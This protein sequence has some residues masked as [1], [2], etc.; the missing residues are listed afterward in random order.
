M[1]EAGFHN[2]SGKT[3][4]NFNGFGN[5]APLG[6]QTRDIRACS[7]VTPVFEALDTHSNG[8][9]FHFHVREVFLPLHGVPFLG[10]IIPA[11][12][13]GFAGV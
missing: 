4:G 5:A 10:A 13:L 3:L 11:S 1:L 12:G 2:F 7:Q 8:D 6:D 9:F